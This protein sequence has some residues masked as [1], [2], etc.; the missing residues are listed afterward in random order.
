V[1]G[2]RARTTGE[3]TEP[4]DLVRVE[5]GR[6]LRAGMPEI[7]EAIFH[8]LRA[9][10]PDTI[11]DDP[12]YEAGLFGAVSD[13]VDHC[14]AVI[15]RGGDGALPLPAQAID[16]ARRAARLGIG[17]ET[18][19]HRVALGERMVYAF[20][21]R[22]ADDLPARDLNLVFES[23]GPAIDHLV[24]RLTEAHRQERERLESGQEGRRVELI[25][26]LLAGARP[27]QFDEATLRYS[28]AG[29]HVS[30]I[31]TG[32]GGEDALRSLAET[33][34]CSLLLFHRG[35][36]TA[37]GWLGGGRERIDFADVRRQPAVHPNGDGSFVVGEP[38]EGLDGWRRTHEQAEAA[39]L[40]G[41]ARPQGL[42][43]AAEVLPE[44]IL[45]KDT[46]A[47]RLLVSTY[48]SALDGLRGK[49]EGARSTLR[50]FLSHGRSISAT[51]A[52]LDVAR[53]TVENRLGEIER[54]T[55]VPLSH[56][57]MT[58]LELAL[59][60]EGELAH[61]ADAV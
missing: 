44:A 18:V 58:R 52:A 19:V 7:E 39:L 9:A 5:I 36:L 53:G 55:G 1:I 14:V 56:E 34:G 49:G 51:A 59:R 22:E 17:A 43:R 10:V 48:L 50:A 8:E 27:D 40:A 45:S 54:A 3:P 16:Q 37:S 31:G 6:R 46:A 13:T 11:G 60:V 24:T 30:L 21:T 33:L 61:P 12:E 4:T 41:R 20:A 29:W 15:E 35:P 57:Q 2:V 23:L 26:R 28:L 38:G 25:K 32:A 42:T 47:A